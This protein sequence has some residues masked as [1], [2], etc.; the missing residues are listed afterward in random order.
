[1]NDLCLLYHH[2][3][4]HKGSIYCLAW[5][6]DTI[7]ASGS[8]D[9]TIKLLSHSPE[10]DTPYSVAGRLDAHAGTVRDM[11]FMRDG[12]LVSGGAGSLDLKI[13]DIASMQLLQS[14][15]G[16]TDQILGVSAV[17]ERVVASGSQDQS[18]RLWDIRQ[19]G[20]PAQVLWA[21]APVSSVSSSAPYIA[22][23]LLNGC[24][25]VWDSRNMSVKYTLKPHS[26]ECRS[27]CYS[28]TGEWILSGSYDGK[29][30]LVSSQGPFWREVCGHRDKVIQCRW[31]SAG[32]VFATTGADKR[33][34]FWRLIHNN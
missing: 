1:M 7:L 28:P 8:N 9:Q 25:C 11:D 13:C 15:E 22:A 5:Y 18:V 29:V 14:C 4:Y 17:S 24:C 20:Q 16:H 26:D 31:H 3:R 10:S 12:L 30:C 2:P 19:G 21:Q 23:A 34:C 6:G 33:A 27:V 32:H